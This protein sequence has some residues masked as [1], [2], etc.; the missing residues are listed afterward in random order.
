VTVTQIQD[1]IGITWVFAIGQLG[2]DI[3]NAVVFD[4]FHEEPVPHKN[5]IDVEKK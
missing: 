3:P 5:A 4:V 1:A 2:G